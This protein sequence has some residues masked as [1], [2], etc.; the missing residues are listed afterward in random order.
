[1][2]TT[3]LGA[4]DAVAIEIARPILP[5]GWHEVVLIVADF[6]PWIA[7]LTEIGGW[8]VVV[9]HRSG[10]ALNALWSMPPDARAEEVLLRNQGETEGYIRL[11]KLSNTPQQR[12]RPDDQAWESGG[13]QAID[14]RTVDMSSTRAALLAR[15]WRAPSD[16]VRYTTYGFDV[17][18]WAPSSPDGIR[19]SFVQRIAPPLVGWPQL[20]RWSRAANAA[21]TVRDMASSTRFLGAALGLTE[22]FHSTTLGSGGHNVMGLPW[23]VAETTQVDIRGFTGVAPGGAAIELIALPQ[24]GG[25][26]HSIDAHPPNLGIAALRLFVDDLDLAATRLTARGVAITAAP[27]LLEIAPYGSCRVMAIRSPD[28]AWLELIERRT[29]RT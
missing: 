18:Q 16:P 23:H 24:L 19:L 10:S 1:M 17:L 11:V 27:G 4:G 21:I 6:E 14:I 9:H 20:K 28:G 3:I 8:E 22:S 25:R 13:L 2:G 12:I 29:E 15:G 7:T 26:D 5:R